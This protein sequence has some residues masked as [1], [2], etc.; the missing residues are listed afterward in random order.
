MKFEVI[1]RDG[2]VV[3]NTEYKECIPSLQELKDMESGG[4]KFRIDGKMVKASNI[5]ALPGSHNDDRAAP[6][7]HSIQARQASVAKD[8]DSKPKKPASKTKTAK[9]KLF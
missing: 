2:A 9:R 6:S 4:Y 5:D 1:N 3:F 7:K 8:Q